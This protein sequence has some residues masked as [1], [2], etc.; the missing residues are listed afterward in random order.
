MTRWTDV[1][2]FTDAP[3]TVATPSARD[4]AEP[5]IV[6][7]SGG[8]DSALALH[9]TLADP[10]L[11][12]VALLTTLSLGD[13]R[14]SVHG[15]PRTLVERQAE[16]LGLPLAVARVPRRASN[17]IYES[18]QRSAL[19]Q[20]RGERVRRVVCGDLFL[21]DVR[22]YRDRLFASVR[23]SGAYPLWGADTGELARRFI[24]LG[25]RAILVAVDPAQLDASFAGRELDEGL[26]HELPRGADPCGERGEFHTFVYDG[27][28]FRE[29]VAVRRGAVVEHD[30][31]VYQDL[32]PG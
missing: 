26:L 15:V 28:I 8:K 21:P 11:R 16:A 30:G 9:A 27:P 7:W 32:T 6:S 29:P 17:E 18:A 20:W 3:S 22:D 31:L 13:D 2:V 23:M 12:V 10:A 25:F 19:L 5:V 24:A 14:V 1:C 4:S